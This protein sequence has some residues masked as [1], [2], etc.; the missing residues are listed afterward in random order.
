MSRSR[1][2]WEISDIAG[3]FAASA[4]SKSRSRGGATGAVISVFDDHHPRRIIPT[5]YRNWILIDE[6]PYMSPFATDFE[7]KL[8]E[9]VER[10][11][12]AGNAC[13][14]SVSKLRL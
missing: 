12:S 4:S 13:F 3:L 14:V 1:S 8:V 6:A 2:S 5:G 10:N 11:L 9:E 7:D